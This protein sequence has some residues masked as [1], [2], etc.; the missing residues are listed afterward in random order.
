M[1]SNLDAQ[2]PAWARRPASSD[3]SSHGTCRLTNWLAPVTAS[4]A[5][6]SSIF[7][8]G[9]GSLPPGKRPNSVPPVPTAHDAATLNRATSPITAPPSMP[10]RPTTSSAGQVG[11]VPGAAQ[12]VLLGDPGSVDHSSF[13]AF[14][15]GTSIGTLPSTGTIMPVVTA[16]LG[17]ATR[18]RR[19]ARGGFLS[20]AGSARRR[21]GRAPRAPRRTPWPAPRPSPR[22]RSRTRTTPS[23]FT[24]LTRTRSLSE[25]GREQPH[26]V[27]LIG[28]GRCRRCCPGPPR[29]RSSTRCR[30]CRPPAPGGPSPVPPHGSRGGALAIT[31]CCRSWS[32]TL[33][34]SS[35][36]TP[37]APRC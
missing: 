24:L 28:L 22:R 3:G 20:G 17:T 25:L 18:P 34:S 21:S 37:T 7:L 4:R 12:L 6:T 27:G 9:R 33:V 23:G 2:D 32:A 15:V 19:R 11:L 13:H 10:E 14:T 16:R 5:A 31:S 36:W 8:G 26:L 1:A 30:R 29:R 35:A